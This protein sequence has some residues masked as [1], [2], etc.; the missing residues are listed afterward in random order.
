M[1]GS[2]KNIEKDVSAVDGEVVDVDQHLRK[3]GGKQEAAGCKI[4]KQLTK[5]D[6]HWVRC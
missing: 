6:A 5:P 1:S 3:K 2:I 4:D